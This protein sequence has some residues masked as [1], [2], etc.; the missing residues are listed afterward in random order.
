LGKRHSMHPSTLLIQGLHYHSR[1]WM[2]HQDSILV[3]KCYC[4]LPTCNND[5]WR[6]P[7]LIKRIY[8]S[9]NKQRFC[10][11]SDNIAARP[12]ME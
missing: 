10:M 8:T 6:L 3:E 2:R 9:W 4:T 12:S 11:I 5:T 1:P 7:N